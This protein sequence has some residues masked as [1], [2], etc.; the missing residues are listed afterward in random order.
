MS[1]GKIAWLHDGTIVTFDGNVITQLTSNDGFKA[2]SGLYLD[3][4]MLVWKRGLAPASPQSGDIFRQTLLPH[5]AFEVTTISGSAPLVVS[6]INRSWEG[7]RTFHWDFGD[8][9]TGNE[10]NTT[11]TYLTPGNYSVTLTVSGPGGSATERKFSLVRVRSVTSASPLEGVI[12]DRFVLHQNYPNP[13][14]PS[15]TIQFE[16]PVRSYV[17]LNV[18]DVLGRLVATLVSNHQS[19]GSHR[20]TWNAAGYASGV[21]VYRLQT[22]GVV[23]SRR[24]L[25]V[26]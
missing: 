15:T 18:Y 22:D 7:S 24:L 11:H 5:A 4:E 14:N 8:G 26:K 17:S 13:F 25:I 20:V 2:Y 1:N 21:Y 23:Q 3:H 10:I 9:S 6:F 12:P 16:L 19:A